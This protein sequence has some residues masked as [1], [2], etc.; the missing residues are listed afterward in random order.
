MRKANH[1]FTVLVLSLILQAQPI[2]AWIHIINGNANR[3]TDFGNAITRDASGNIIIAGVTD[4]LNTDHDFTVIKFDQNGNELWH[5]AIN[6]AANADDQANAVAVDITGNVIA[7]GFTTNIG[8]LHD[9]T[10]VK[11]DGVTGGE[12]WRRT[13]KGTANL[14]DHANAVTTDPNGNVIAAGFT[15]NAGTGVNFTVIKFN[16]VTGAELW[17]Q[18]IRGTANGNDQANALAIDVAGNVFAVGSLWNLDTSLDFTVIKFN[19]ANGTEIW[20]Q[21]VSVF[22]NS[23]HEANAIALDSSGNVFAAGYTANPRFT[24]IKFNG[25]TGDELWWQVLGTGIARALAIESSGDVIAGG[26]LGDNFSVIKFNGATGTEQWRQSTGRGDADSIAID[27]A[28]NLFA[29]GHI[30]NDYAVLKLN[31]GTGSEQW[32]RVI[33][34]TYTSSFPSN[35]ARAVILDQF[36]DPVATGFLADRNTS[37]DIITAKFNGLNGDERWRQITNGSATNSHDEAV[38]ITITPSGNVAAGGFTDNFGTELDFTVVQLNGVNGAAQWRHIINGTSNSLD[39]ARAVATDSLGDVF[40]AGSIINAGSRIFTLLKFRGENGGELWRHVMAG[41]LGNALK[42]DSA[43]NIIAS[44]SGSLSKFDNATGEELWFTSGTTIDS[45][46][47]SSTD[48]IFTG[49]VTRIQ[50]GKGGELHFSVSKFDTR[51]GEELWRNVV[52]SQPRYGNRARA[53]AVD[54]EGG[55]VAAGSISGGGFTVI[56]FEGGFGRIL[57]DHAE[58]GRANAVATDSIG[59]VFAA[60]LTRESDISSNFTIMKL[61][62]ETGDEQWRQAIRGSAT[63][64]Y[65]PNEALAVA[66][67]S[68]GD[69][70]A[71]GFITN[72]ITGSDFT[73]IKFNGVTGEEI[74]RR[75]ISGTRVFSNDQALAVT[76]DSA[77]DVI[78]AGFTENAGAGRDFT[79]V[80]LNGGNGSDF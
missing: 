57:W 8:M 1:F 56:K 70:V 12:T 47:I 20:R 55:V 31:G 71:A 6:G 21:V 72:N 7:A 66:V 32:R 44:A 26:S 23:R 50:M 25:A 9:F 17:R 24:I 10:V 49:G 54:N 78:A 11:L 53:V 3:S 61:D 58:N 42:L 80:K 22:P 46:A 18:V 43:E 30:G 34:G 29:A 76:I 2:N 65:T 68:S 15:M 16:G 60:G 39:E 28:G 73:V 51:D 64:G 48:D 79:V 4:N 74:W 75:I 38:A 63:I 59:D 40:A 35:E 41:G 5:R 19:G 27:S 45:I 69:V 52:R 13:I 37:L 62:G 77:G 67:D 36:G 33:G 14:H